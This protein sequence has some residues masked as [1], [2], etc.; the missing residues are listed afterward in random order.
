MP[1][2]RTL[3]LQAHGPK[4]YLI[5]L[6]YGDAQCSMFLD[7]SLGILGLLFDV[8]RFPHHAQSLLKLSAGDHSHCGCHALRAP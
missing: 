7:V 4:K 8:M 5:K 2:L 3:D 6:L 1:F